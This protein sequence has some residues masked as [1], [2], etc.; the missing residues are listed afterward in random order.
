GSQKKTVYQYNIDDGSL[1]NSFES[2]D[3]AA[4]AVNAD[5]KSISRACLNVNHL[6]KGFFWSYDLTVPFV[7]NEDR[8]QKKVIQKDLNGAILATYV[9]VA[10][11]SRQTGISKSPIAKTCRGE[12]SLAGG[13]IWSYRQ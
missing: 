10:E 9:S 7:V 5:K 12:Q 2:L 3:C 1:I 6:Y 13:F 4:S 11:A 8:R